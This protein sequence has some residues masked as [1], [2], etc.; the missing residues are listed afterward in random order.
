MKVAA[1]LLALAGSAAAFAPSAPAQSATQL[2]A[3][4]LDDIGGSTAPLKNYDPLRLSLLGSDETLLW[5]RAAELK[6][7]RCAMVATTGYLINAAGFHFPGMLSTSENISFESLSNMS[8]VDAWA[9]VPDA[10]KAQI[11]GT[12]FVAELYTES[13]GTHY[14]KGGKMPE[15]VFP[16]FDFSGVSAETLETKR[17]REL[18]NGRLAMIAIMSFISA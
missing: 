8:P 17:C 5:F 2:S 11:I 6:H 1:L 3:L 9:A 12:I 16:K 15:V 10:G 4:T 14:T 13:Q 7:A 18:N